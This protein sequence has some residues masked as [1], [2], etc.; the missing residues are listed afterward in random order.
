M[1]IKTYLLMSEVFSNRRKREI[2][3]YVAKNKRKILIKFHR[4][5]K[6]V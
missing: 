5:A 3:Y 4:I 6:V 2:M 1:K